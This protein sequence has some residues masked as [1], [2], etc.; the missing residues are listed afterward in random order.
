MDKGVQSIIEDC[1]KATV[2][3]HSTVFDK[4]K[5]RNYP[6]SLAISVEGLFST[7][8]NVQRDELFRLGE[9]NGTATLFPFLR[10][11]I[12]DITRTANVDPLILPLVNIYRLV[13]TQKQLSEEKSGCPE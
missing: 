3:L 11:V 9:I 12:A 10:S 5:E 4:A 1:R 6:F 7:S 8:E 2:T 13:E